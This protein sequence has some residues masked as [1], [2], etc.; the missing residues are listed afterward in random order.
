M[1]LASLRYFFGFLA[2]LFFLL[3]L[4]ADKDVVVCLDI[5][6]VIQANATDVVPL[7]AI[8]A[9]NHFVGLRLPANAIQFNFLKVVRRNVR[10]KVVSLV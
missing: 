2:L 1:R 4:S 6:I 5:L 10:V 8:F 9:H 3:A 7:R